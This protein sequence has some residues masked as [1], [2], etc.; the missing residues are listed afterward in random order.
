[1]QEQSACY[2]KMT[3]MY[4]LWLVTLDLS[5]DNTQRRNGK[6]RQLRSNRGQMDKLNSHLFSPFSHMATSFDRQLKS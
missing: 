6:N 2:W 4:K 1:M 3:D 5:G